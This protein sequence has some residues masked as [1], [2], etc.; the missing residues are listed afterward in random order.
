M[1]DEKTLPIDI[2]SVRQKHS[3]ALAEAV[4]VTFWATAARDTF[5]A[6]VT[7]WS[8]RRDRFLLRNRYPLPTHGE[9]APEA[10]EGTPGTE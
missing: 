9:M 2:A 1:A 3:S 10:P 8:D 7:E 6:Q 5:L 4:R